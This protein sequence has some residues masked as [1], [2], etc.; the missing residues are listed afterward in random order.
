[1]VMKPEAKKSAEPKDPDENR[2]DQVFFLSAKARW[3]HVQARANL[4]EIGK[5]PG[6]GL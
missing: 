6:E 1:M 5:Q 4:P 2:A 3:S